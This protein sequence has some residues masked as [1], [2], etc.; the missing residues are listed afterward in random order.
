MVVRRKFIEINIL[1]MSHKVLLVVEHFVF[2]EHICEK[3]LF[4]NSIKFSQKNK[5]KIDYA[6]ISNNKKYKNFHQKSKIYNFVCFTAKCYPSF[7]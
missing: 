6:E 5:I 2:C 4:F 3:I 1:P 7:K